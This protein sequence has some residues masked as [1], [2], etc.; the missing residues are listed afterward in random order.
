[1]AT[2]KN[3]EVDRM[4]DELL[5]GKSPEETLIKCATFKSLVK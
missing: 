3:A 2:E 5:K 4:L 1:M